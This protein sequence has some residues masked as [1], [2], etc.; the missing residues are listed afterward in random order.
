MK[1]PNSKAKVSK[2]P[3]SKAK[4]PV[5][6]LMLAAES[7]GELG[8]RLHDHDRSRGRFRE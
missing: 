5:D 8:E 4:H 7:C 3:N 6:S 1:T 2:S